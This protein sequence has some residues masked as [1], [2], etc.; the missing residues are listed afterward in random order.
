MEGSIRA[1]MAQLNG[2]KGILAPSAQADGGINIVLFG[3]EGVK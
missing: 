2:Y 1:R 3:T